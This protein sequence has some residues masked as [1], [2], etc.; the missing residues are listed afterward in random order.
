MST[1]AIVLCSNLSAFKEIVSDG[2]NGFLYEEGEKSS[3][4]E[5]LNEIKSLNLVELNAIRNN[6]LN[7]AQVNYSWDSIAMEYKKLFL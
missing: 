1:G 3:F 2:V 5:K 6:A 4:Q 7:Y